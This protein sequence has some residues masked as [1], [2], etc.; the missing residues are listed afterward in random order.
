MISAARPEG[1]VNGWPIADYKAF[2]AE[3]EKSND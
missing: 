1:H 3:R 2:L